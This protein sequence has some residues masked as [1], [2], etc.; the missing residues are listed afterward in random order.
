MKGILLAAGEYA[1]FVESDD[2][3]ELNMFE[4]LYNT[5]KEQNADIVK[6]NWFN[7]WSKIINY[8]YKLG[9]FTLDTKKKKD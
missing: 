7:Y 5:A 4:V 8:K 3:V 9:I 1:G 2:F 6:S